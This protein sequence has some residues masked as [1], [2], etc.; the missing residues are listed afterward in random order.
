MLDNNFLKVALAI[1][2]IKKSEMVLPIAKINAITTPF[3]LGDHQALKT[4]MMSPQNYDKELIKC[5]YK[6]SQF[7]DENGVEI[8]KKTD[9]NR[10]VKLSFDD[11]QSRISNIDK[12]FLVWSCYNSTYGTLGIRE[13]ECEQCKKK[14]KYKI[15]LEELIRPDTM[16][17]W[18]RETPFNETVDTIACSYGDEYEYVFECYIPTIKKYNQV[19]GFISID[20]IRENLESNTVLS[21]SEDLAVQ[22]KTI[23]IKKKGEEIARSNNIQEVL[24]VLESAIPTKVTEEFK[25]KYTDLYQ[26]FIPKFYT[27]LK[28]DECEHENKYF[29]DIETEFF[30][31]I[32]FGGEFVE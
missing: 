13:I 24:T 9:D 14:N 1:K 26:K 2:D 7:F 29:V 18:D 3:L 27:L 16:T 30:R 31:R 11:I 28:C 4:A 32:L 19:L 8:K 21:E 10:E 15:T 12:I 22:I 5:L 25:K 23:I 6:H 20:K 17:L